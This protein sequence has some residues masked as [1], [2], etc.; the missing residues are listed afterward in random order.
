METI[1][2]L[3]E[4]YSAPIVLLIAFSSAMIYVLKL[5]VEKTVSTHFDRY[6]KEIE[7]KLNRR[8]EFE[9]KVLLDRYELVSDL[10]NRIERVA[11]DLNRARHGIE[12]QGLFEKGDLVPLSVI[13]EDL[14]SKR[15]LL[16]ERFYQFFWNQSQVV[17][18]I[19]N[20]KDKSSL[21]ELTQQYIRNREKFIRA[22]N[23]VFGIDKIS[24]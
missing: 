23:K 3:V 21:E 7:L 2:K 20:A 13:F 16:T 12:V 11:S 18:K 10:A 4:Q 24:W 5:V 17:L 14:V 9:Q 22:V 19:A 6:S 1:I 8:S 15:Y